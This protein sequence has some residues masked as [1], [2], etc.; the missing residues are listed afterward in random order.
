MRFVL[1]ILLLSIVTSCKESQKETTDFLKTGKLQLAPPHVEMTSTII[2]TSI[3]VA[4]HFNMNGARIHYTTDGSDPTLQDLEYTAPLIIDEPGSYK[5]ASFHEDWLVSNSA[6]AKAYKKGHDP[7]E[8]IWKTTASS[9]YPGIDNQ[10]LI[11]HKKASKDF[12]DVHWTGFD[13]TAVATIVF[14]Q[15]MR[16]EKLTVGYLVDTKSW[17]FPPEKVTL[18]LNDTDTITAAIKTIEED[19]SKLD[20]IE[21]P[22]NRAVERMELRVQNL[23]KLPDWHAGKGAKAWLFMDEWIFN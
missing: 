8:I 4:A 19:S 22:I 5:F 18:I 10:S 7:Q 21:I 13:T 1:F 20:D 14:K 11:N 17:I 16:I 2:D 6:F 15:R 12:K 3:I 9:T 23:R